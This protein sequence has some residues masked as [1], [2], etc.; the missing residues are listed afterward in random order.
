MTK[1]VD[2][3]LYDTDL[4]RERVKDE[5]IICVFLMIIKFLL[6]WAPIFEL[7]KAGIPLSNLA[8]MNLSLLTL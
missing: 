3:F 5:G 8:S 4:R 6:I 1:V 2:W 7:P